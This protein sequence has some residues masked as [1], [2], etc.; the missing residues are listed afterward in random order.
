MATNVI[1]K[2]LSFRVEISTVETAIA[3]IFALTPPNTATGSVEVPTLDQA[4]AG[5]ARQPTGYARASQVSGSIYLD[6]ATAAHRQLITMSQTPGTTD[7]DI[8]LADT[9]TSE[10]DWTAA[11][12]ELG[13][14]TELEGR[15]QANFSSNV[16]GIPTYTLPS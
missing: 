7:C 15:L 4:G 5:V 2:G 8:V 13:I 9:D 14:V 6:P 3:E 16:S 11:D 10:I 12:F 1:V